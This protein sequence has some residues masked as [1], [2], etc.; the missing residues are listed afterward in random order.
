MT[1]WDWSWARS[2][3]ADAVT[4]PNA[5]SPAGRSA[6]PEVHWASRGVER[7]SLPGPVAVVGDIHGESDLLRRLLDE[8]GDM[9]VISVGDVVDRGPDSKGAIDLVLER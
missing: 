1:D 4:T 5:E 9:P 6:A 8:L 2:T 7:L 3:E